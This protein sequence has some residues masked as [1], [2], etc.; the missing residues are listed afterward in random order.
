MKNTTKTDK[1]TRF[2][3]KLAPRFDR[4][5]EK[6][7]ATYKL[8]TDKVQGYLGKNDFVCDFGCGTGL[9]SNPIAPFVRQ[10]KAID[11]SSKMIEI[12]RNKATELGIGNIEFTQT[13]IFDSSL[14]EGSFDVVIAAYILHLVDDIASVIIRINKLLKPGGL[15]LSVTPCLGDAAFLRFMLSAA[16]FTGL[17]PK[18]KA[19]KVS[20][21]ESKIKCASFEI[22][23]SVCL[24]PDGQQQFIAAKKFM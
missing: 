19:F 5:E 16:A 8:M 23:E 4:Y 14:A 13:N 6:S 10:I 1:S 17:V 22:N 24:N 2:W 20:N 15:M 21:L 11:I 9:V 12:A 3:D 7:E 18:T